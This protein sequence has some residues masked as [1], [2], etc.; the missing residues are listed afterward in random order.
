[1]NDGEDH[2]WAG[3]EANDR[4]LARLADGELSDAEYARVLRELD[5]DPR[6]WRDCALAFLEAQA[7]RRGLREWTGIGD[8]APRQEKPP[9]RIRARWTRSSLPWSA[10]GMAVTVLLAF[11][12]GRFTPQESQR[13]GNNST[14]NSLAQSQA[15]ETQP[16]Q[17]VANRQGPDAQFVVDDYWQGHS[18]FSPEVRKS[19]ERSGTDVRRQ[20]RYI[21]VRTTTGQQLLVPIVDV[22]LVPVGNRPN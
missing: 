5:A 13:L 10:L 6:K 9:V 1:M 22:Q 15:D 8:V 11:S 17:T 19:L 21:P 4:T 18:L 7:L 20:H 3:V 16:I 2:P 12:L 14:R